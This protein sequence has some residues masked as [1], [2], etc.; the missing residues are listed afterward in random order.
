M[1]LFTE[2]IYNFDL[3]GITRYNDIDRPIILVNIADIFKYSPD[4]FFNIYFR[5]R[6]NFTSDK[7]F[8]LAAHY[9]DATTGSLIAHQKRVEQCVT[10]LITNFIRMTTKNNFICI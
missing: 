2:I 6:G 4:N 10:D 5:T 8:S 1:T 3:V 9:F 7:D